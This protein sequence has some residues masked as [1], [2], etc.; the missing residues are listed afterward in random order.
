MS[1]HHTDNSVISDVYQN[2]LLIASDDSVNVSAKLTAMQK[3]IYAALWFT[4]STAAFVKFVAAGVYRKTGI[5]EGAWPRRC[6]E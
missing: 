3:D 2:I 4:I 5:K 6:P 1:I